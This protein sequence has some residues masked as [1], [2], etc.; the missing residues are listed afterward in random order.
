MSVGLSRF[1]NHIKT[2]LTDWIAIL[3]SLLAF[4]VAG[5]A[6]YFSEFKKAEIKIGVGQNVFITRT[7]R[8]G[9]PCTFT[10]SG[11]NQ[12]V[13][14]D[15]S[16][17][18]GNN[19]VNFEWVQIGTLEQWAIDAQGKQETK[20]PALYSTATPIAVKQRDQTT[21]VLWFG[22][23]E[24][25]FKF[26]AGPTTLTLSVYSDSKEEIAKHQFKIDIPYPVVETMYK[27]NFEG[28]PYPVSR[29]NE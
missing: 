1:W 3:V 6:L 19:P 12:I 21:A 5:F 22:I 23:G 4:I 13:I 20:S 7:P 11:A 24:T 15:A 9:I 26:I 27:S 29:S 16:L 18:C 10:N 28:V 17:Q 8:I 2:H 14:T 25:E